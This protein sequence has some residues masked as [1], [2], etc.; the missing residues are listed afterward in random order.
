MTRTQA[1]AILAEREGTPP[2]HL[3]CCTTEALIAA[4]R[5]PEGQPCAD[6]QALVVYTDE[7]GWRHVEP[8]DCFLA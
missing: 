5:A 3:E 8:S 1:E 7:T 2:E 4:A 6:C